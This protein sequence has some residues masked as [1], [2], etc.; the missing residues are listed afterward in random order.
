MIE[1]LLPKTRRAILGLLFR[2][3]TEAFYEREIMRAIDGGRGAVQRELANLT[4][5]GLVRRDVRGDRVYYGANEECPIFPELRGLILKTVGLV[6][7]LRAALEGVHGVRLAFVYG[8]F[9]R[10]EAGPESD[11]DLIVVGDVTFAHISRALRTA[12]DRLGRVMNP[13][14]YSVGEFREKL[15][16]RHPFLR[17]VLSGGKLFVVGDAHVLAELAGEGLAAQASGQS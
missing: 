11:V 13:T 1:A 12:H 16:D 7:V 17:R 6:D 2:N 15:A 3:P 14:V 4:R 5:F 10:G 8:S 9:A